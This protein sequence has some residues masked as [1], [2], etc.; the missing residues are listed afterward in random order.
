L[1]FPDARMVFLSDLEETRSIRPSDYD[2]V[3]VPTCYA[4]VLDVSGADMF[5]NTASLGEMRNETIRY[6]MDF[7]QHRTPVKHLFTQNRFLI[8]SIRC[9]THGGGMKMK[10]RCT[11]TDRGES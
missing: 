8:L 4:D 6:W 11:M 2:F 3:F 5:V 9:S 7:V 1:N 10:R